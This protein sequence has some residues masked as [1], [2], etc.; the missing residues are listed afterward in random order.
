MSIQRKIV[1]ALAAFGLIPAAVLFVIY[2]LGEGQS[3]DALYGRFHNLADQ[4][5][6]AVDRTL[7]ERYGD[8]QA[9][10]LN[11]AAQDADNWGVADI[12]NPLIEAMNGYV[13]NYGVYDLM[14]LVDTDGTVIGV[15]TK[16]ATGQKIDTLGLL[17]K[18]FADRS[19]FKALS[20][21]RFLE[22][23]DGLT[24]TVVEGPGFV[25]E[26]AAVTG[27]D[28]YVLT[29]AASVMPA[30]G[31]TIAYWVNFANLGFVDAMV[32]EFHKH[33]AQDGMT[34]AEF[35]ILDGKGTVITDYATAPNGGPYV[36]DTAV[37]G[38]RNLVTEGDA[39]ARRAA[40][41]ESGAV[42][43]DA[44]AG[45]ARVVGVARSEGANRF[46]GLG[47][48]ALVRVDADQVFAGLD[49]LRLGMIVTVGLS[50][51]VILAA[52]FWIGRSLSAP[53]DAMVAAMGRL[54]AGDMAVTV[55]SLD[56]RD[57]IGAMAKAVEVFKQA[58]ID[59]ARLA[60]EAE[61]A[62]RA[63]E[64]EREQRREA[65]A[66]AEAERHAREEAARRQSEQQRRQD[67]Q[68]LAEAFEATVQGVVDAVAGAAA[69][70]QRDATGM[71]A[72]ADGSREQA[73]I[74]ADAAG[75]ATTNVQTVATAAEQLSASVQE[76]ARR[77]T[78]SAEIAASA[79]REAEAT[80]RTMRSLA[81]SAE[82]IDEVL[83]LITAIA[84]QTNLLALNA[85][86]EAARAGDAGKGFAVVASEVKNL[87]TQTARATDEI[88][89]KIRSIQEQT[90]Q[91]V[92]A[93][94]GI[95]RTIASIN[96][97]TAGIAG[98]VEQ[99]GA[100]TAEIARNVAEAADGTAR[101]SGT[102][103]E[104]ERATGETGQQAGGVLAAAN[105]LSRQSATLEQEVRRFI[106]RVRAA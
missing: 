101:V 46:P 105:D 37:V 5:V 21:R 34:S 9:F 44:A 87:A 53:V 45:P 13:R 19:W 89:T 73:G 54:A 8:A 12:G 26:V 74:V 98:A 4:M 94:G 52:G 99:Q 33:L 2:L 97:I 79:V 103:V 78:Q 80:D 29:F 95:G 6:D 7:A 17:N 25:P 3:R 90:E 50:A 69:R 38:H 10:A 55:P 49:A 100:A 24:G 65:D 70:L 39:A 1:L 91:A 48:S 40:A 85:T 60:A 77:I 93:I 61:R 75:Q 43:E 57:E 59:N 83:R 22:G 76:I 36:R 64:A 62:R 96:D 81:S 14:L 106:A 23:R 18:N 66:R 102:I 35:T 28:G 92:T 67:M 31:R 58:G 47:W 20:E 42:L 30:G 56:R 68:S 15:N 104:V 51:V 16:D 82:E 32:G 63:A 41:G 88:G 84:N 72:T 27:G 86:I 11:T 71:S